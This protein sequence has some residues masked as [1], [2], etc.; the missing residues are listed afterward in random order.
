MKVLVVHSGF[1]EQELWQTRA[2]LE[3]QD[4]QVVVLDADTEVKEE[5]RRTS[6]TSLVENCEVVVIL[7]DG[8]L[9]LADVQVSI[10]VAKAKGKKVVG[11]RLTGAGTNEEF[12]KFGSAL[13]PFVREKIVSVV[14]GDL[15]EWTD[16]QGEPRAEPDTDRHVCKKKKSDAAA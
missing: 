16:E 1:C 2:T 9:S 11:I 15:T 13:I 14:C 12:E 6:I 5:K 3:A 10:L 7:F 8:N 4:C